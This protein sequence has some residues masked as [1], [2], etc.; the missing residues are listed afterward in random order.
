MK[1]TLLALRKR[2]RTHAVFGCQDPGIRINAVEPGSTRT[3]LN[4]NTGH[5]PVERGAEIIVRM[6][7]VGRDGPTGCYFALDGPLPW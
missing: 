4:G 2:D 6:A 3:G 7:T 1:W 5:Q